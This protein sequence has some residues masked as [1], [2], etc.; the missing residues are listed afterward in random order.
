MAKNLCFLL[1]LFLIAGCSG[2]GSESPD[3]TASQPATGPQAPPQASLIWLSSSGLFRSHTDGTGRITLDD[4]PG[5]SRPVLV[6]STSI[7]YTREVNRLRDVWAVQLNGTGKH[8]LANDQDDEILRDA[9]G[10]WAIYDRSPGELR[11]NNIWS[12]SLDG[13][14][15]H[16][17]VAANEQ[18]D[19]QFSGFHQ[20]Q[21]A[22]RAV[23]LLSCS[24]LRVDPSC[25]QLHSILPNGSDPRQLTVDSFIPFIGGHVGNRLIYSQFSS[26]EAID[27]DILSVPVTGGP[28]TPLANS[29]DYESERAD[30]I[31]GSRV[32]Y[33]RCVVRPPSSFVGQCDVYSVNG[34][35][36]GTI[37]L[38][39]HPDNERV[40]GLIGS[41]VI[42]RRNSGA[43]DTLFSIPAGGGAETPMLTIDAQT[44]FVVGIVKDRVILRRPTGLWSLKADGE[45]LTQLTN[46]VDELAGSAGEFVCF[47]RGQALWCVPA[48]GSAEP[49]QVTDNGVFVEGL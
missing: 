32:V 23:Y 16:L 3:S 35:G 29:Q 4:Q 18:L 8:V 43:T 15:A 46:Q 45:S 40:Q 14:Q 19:Q 17:L 27:R 37:A 20:G 44:E 42:V 5:V 6:S 1:V 24:V 30:L 2:G 39:T 26:T 13:Q 49:T 9:F 33:H 34:D 21:A 11:G 28:P 25:G 12:V 31:T 22:G 47:A 38:S 36:S 48:D 7:V 41:R 10:S